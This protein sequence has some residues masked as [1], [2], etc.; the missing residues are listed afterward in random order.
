MSGQH[1]TVRQ[2]D[3]LSSLAARHG[4]PDW[5]VIYDAP[6]NEELRKLRPNPNLIYPGDR[7]FIPDR[8]PK[9]EAA[10]TGKSHTFV[11]SRPKT[12]L[13]LKIFDDLD[14][15]PTKARYE[16]WIEGRQKPIEGDLEDGVLDTK[17]PADAPK[18]RLVIRSADRGTVLEELELLLGALDPVD[19]VSGARSRLRRLGFD[20][21][22]VAK[23]MNPAIA[24]ALRLFQRVYNLK[25]DGTL[26]PATQD[27]LKELIGC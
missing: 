23:E 12:R 26:S 15:S 20:C 2:G 21:G 14:E 5:H 7:V 8:R 6:E 27:K 4:L 16:L 3:C 9:L 11:V 17:I 22:P 25:E 10:A 24:R 19:T 18:A 1:H 13:R